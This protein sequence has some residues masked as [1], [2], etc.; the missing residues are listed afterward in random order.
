MGMLVVCF[1]V[2]I[3]DEVSQRSLNLKCY[4]FFPGL[5]HSYEP[6]PQNESLVSLKFPD[7]QPM[8]GTSRL[9]V[10]KRTVR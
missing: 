7:E 1:G 3:V 8:L 6:H 4:N 10:L 2:K 5:V 9:N